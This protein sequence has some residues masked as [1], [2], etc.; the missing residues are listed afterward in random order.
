[1]LEWC[2]EC[3]AKNR[4]LDSCSTGAA[5]RVI[6]LF[7][8]TGVEFERYETG[9]FFFAEMVKRFSQEKYYFCQ[10]QEYLDRKQESGEDTREYYTA[11]EKLWFHAYKIQIRGVW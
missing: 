4:M 10:E 7:Y 3:D 2:E 6:V 8:Q 5:R 11:K 9:V 1:M